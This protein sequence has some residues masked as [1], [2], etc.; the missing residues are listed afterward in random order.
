[1]WDGNFQPNV[2]F[3][4]RADIWVKRQAFLDGGPSSR[5]P[6]ARTRAL[7][8]FKCLIAPCQGSFSCATIST[9]RRTKYGSAGSL[10][11]TLTSPDRVSGIQ[12]CR[13]HRHF[14]GE[15][16]ALTIYFVPPSNCLFPSLVLPA[17]LHRKYGHDPPFSSSSAEFCSG[18]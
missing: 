11:D 15:I 17:S 10:G 12:N 3:G 9:T 6:A 18:R 8:N 14:H 5:F 1:M 16:D 7:C 4:D 13:R 2:R